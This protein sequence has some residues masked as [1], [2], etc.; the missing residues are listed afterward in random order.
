VAQRHDKHAVIPQ[1]QTPPRLERELAFIL[2]LAG[3]VLIG[4]AFGIFIDIRTGSGWD[5]PSNF[6]L[7][8]AFGFAGLGFLC[9]YFD[10]RHWWQTKNYLALAA[11]PIGCLL[12]IFFF[13]SQM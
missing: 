7:P 10:L 4:A 1:T 8:V 13:A 9:I 11:Y 12:L 5:I 3:I 2:T 6:R